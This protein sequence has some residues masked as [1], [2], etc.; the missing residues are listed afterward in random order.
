M[1]CPYLVLPSD[2]EFVHLSSTSNRRH[3][4]SITAAT[5]RTAVVW[6]CTQCMSEYT[7]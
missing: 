2:G 3:Q 4:P 6:D 5:L 7:Q 1:I